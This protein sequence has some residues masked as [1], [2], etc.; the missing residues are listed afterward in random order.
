MSVEAAKKGKTKRR[1]LAEYPIAVKVEVQEALPP[2]G[3]IGAEPL[4]L[5]PQHVSRNPAKRCLRAPTANAGFRL[6]RRLL[7]AKG[8]LNQGLR[9]SV[10][11]TQCGFRDYA[12]FYRAFVG[13][14]GLSPREYQAF[15][16]RER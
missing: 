7:L 15:V 8:L 3:V 6:K 12:T 1:M 10:I 11:Y 14:Y 4:N 2:A 9:P 13:E 16:N 5:A